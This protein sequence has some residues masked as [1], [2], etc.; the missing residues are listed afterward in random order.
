MGNQC[1]CLDFK[2]SSDFPLNRQTSTQSDIKLP[3]SSTGFTVNPIISHP[4]PNYQ[5]LLL[6]TALQARFRGLLFRKRFRQRKTGINY[7][8]RMI[9]STFDT[10]YS[11]TDK[12]I[13]VNVI[14]YLD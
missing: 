10:N 1:N 12:D 8:Q 9:S 7:K 3:K 14:N 2:E 6:V 13:I 11:F 5:Q 4:N